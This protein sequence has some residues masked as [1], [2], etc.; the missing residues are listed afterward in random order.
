MI[1]QQPRA[2]IRTSSD[3]QT[4]IDFKNINHFCT[5]IVLFSNSFEQKQQNSLYPFLLTLL[6]PSYHNR[7]KNLTIFCS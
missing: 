4:V 2:S 3:E 5:H 6:L 1:K 7:K